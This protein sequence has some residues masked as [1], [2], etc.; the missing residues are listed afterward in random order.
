[1]SIVLD[2]SLGITTTVPIAPAD[3]GTGLTAPGTS[4][5][6]L[7]SNG[8]AWTSSATGEIGVGQTWSA[9][10]RAAGTTYTNS[11]TKPIMVS[12][13]V[14]V[15][16]SANGNITLTVGGIQ[17]YSSNVSINSSGGAL[18]ALFTFIVPVGVSYVIAFTGSGLS[19][20]KWSELS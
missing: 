19:V 18:P 12:I 13:G 2:G 3:G 8:T 1:M 7:T 15:N 17:L 11:G 5:N 6:V 4:G 9:P 14:N 10:T 20:N 16:T